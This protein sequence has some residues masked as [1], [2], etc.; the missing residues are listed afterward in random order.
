MN[1]CVQLGAVRGV[2]ARGR[3]AARGGV[4]RRPRRQERPAPVEAALRRG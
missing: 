3:G 2:G 1:G 4:P